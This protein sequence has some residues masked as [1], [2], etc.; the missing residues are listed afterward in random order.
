[1][2]SV[3]RWGALLL[4]ATYLF[5]FSS[6]FAVDNPVTTEMATPA[7]T[8]EEFLPAFYQSSRNATTYFEILNSQ[9]V[10]VASQFYQDTVSFFNANNWESIKQHICDEGLSIRQYQLKDVAPA[11]AGYVYTWTVRQTVVQEIQ[12]LNGTFTNYLIAN[13]EADIECYID[14]DND[15]GIINSVDERNVRVSWE[16]PYWGLYDPPIIENVDLYATR[17]ANGSQATIGV[18]YYLW[19]GM[20]SNP[21][22]NYDTHFTFTKEDIPNT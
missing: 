20:K 7:A 12:N 2:K 5:T 11:R 1:M 17:T 15:I 22:G 14:I 21:C 10:D 6:V 16:H 18:R 3:H 8:L 13:L 9:N 4:V 19:A